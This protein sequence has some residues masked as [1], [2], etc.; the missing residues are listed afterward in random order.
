MHP[1]PV[2]PLPADDG[3]ALPLPSV[4]SERGPVPPRL[5]FL[6][7][8]EIICTIVAPTIEDVAFVGLIVLIRTFLSLSPQ[9]ELVGRW[10]CPPPRDDR[11]PG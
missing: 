4:P 7:A 1:K 11:P 2:S 3:R 9:L 10:P 8:A 5:E 6:V